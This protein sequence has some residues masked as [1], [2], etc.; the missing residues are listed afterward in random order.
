MARST[1]DLRLF[2]AIYPPKEIARELLEWLGAFDLPPHRL[3]PIDQVHLTLQFIGDVTPGRLKE[4]IESVERSA[5]GLDAFE[6]QLTQFG[7]IAAARTCS[8]DCSRGRSTSGTD[9]NSAAPRASSGPQSARQGRRSIPSAFH[10]RA[11]PQSG[12]IQFQ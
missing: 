5:A 12:P 2:I 8:I 3:T 6:M 4:T 10:A 7:S 9:G 1:K 11:F